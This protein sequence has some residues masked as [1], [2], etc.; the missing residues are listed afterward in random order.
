MPTNPGS[1]NPQVDCL[2]HTL[3]YRRYLRDPRLVFWASLFLQ[4]L[5]SNGTENECYILHSWKVEKTE[6]VDKWDVVDF[7]H[8]TIAENHGK[9]EQANKPFSALSQASLVRQTLF[10][11]FSK[12]CS[13]TLHTHFVHKM[14]HFLKNTGLK[15]PK[16]ALL[17]VLLLSCLA[18]K[19]A[20]CIVRSDWT[21]AGICPAFIE[22]R[23]ASSTGIITAFEKCTHQSVS[24]YI[25]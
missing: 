17:I 11:A 2:H 21:S 10:H 8:P 12:P 22:K 14:L 1:M 15:K 4:A 5:G 25:F 9:Y 13:W 3:Q 6:F 23:L 24:F 16:A 19:R 20:L 18:G 7:V